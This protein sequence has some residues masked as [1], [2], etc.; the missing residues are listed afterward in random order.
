MSQL[1]KM[2][3]TCSNLN[4]DGP[5][6]RGPPMRSQKKISE[7]SMCNRSINASRRS[8]S[9]SNISISKSPT[10]VGGNDF[11]RIERDNRGEFRRRSRSSTASPR[12]ICAGDRFIPMRSAMN[13]DLAHIMLTKKADSPSM[14][15]FQKIVYDLRGEDITNQKILSYRKKAPV[16]PD[17][18]LNPMRVLY[19]TTK[20]PT[21]T[22]KKG[23]RYIPTAPDRILDAPDILDDYY[24]N[25]VDWNSSNILA[26]ALGANV[27]LWNAG[28]G[29]IE[30]LL[31][32]EG[33]D[34]VCSVSWIQNGDFLAVGTTTGAVELWDC[35]N[36]KRLRS[37]AGH[38]A[39]VGAL[40]WN[41][42]VVSSGARS[43]QIVHHD[44]RQREHVIGTVSAHGQ[45]ICGLK[46]SPDGKF[47]ASG[48]NDNLLKIWSVAGGGFHSKNKPIHSFNHHVA[49]VKALAW[50]PWQ[51]N[52][53]ASGG[54][55][56]DRHI[57]FWNINSGVCV[58]AIDTKSQVCSLLWSTH[59]KE[60]VSGHG[61]ANHEIIIWKYPTMT[62]V[63]ELLGHTS[64]V[65]H[66]AMSPDG[67]TVLSAGADETLRLWKC[68]TLDHIKKKTASHGIHEK[69]S[70]LKQS[71]R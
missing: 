14:K 51:N 17:G 6:T 24:L 32:L 39:R 36:F 11:T 12:K 45:E 34:Y 68:F 27:Y 1:K 59:Y 29:N 37:M 54:G 48:G 13:F 64:R 62:K 53:L 60:I 7:T 33:D 40:S 2:T 18:Y 57:R 10:R 19:S 38:S 46:W 44:V 47:L 8:L 61:F 63:T 16:A 49:A 4:V 21:S 58:N 15:E 56:A 43:G 3:E 5:I 65:L 50:C 20:T 52:I 9:V 55:T 23:A 70:V 30:Q 69:R 42:H 67:T 28:T 25:L 31:E 66:L 41:S 22:S 26:A 71:I 35:A